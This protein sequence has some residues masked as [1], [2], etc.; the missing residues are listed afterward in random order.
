[1][2]FG[3]FRSTPFVGRRASGAD[4]RIKHRMRVDRLFLLDWRHAHVAPRRR[5]LVGGTGTA[6]PVV[7][8][9]EW[10]RCSDVD[11]D[12]SLSGP[13]VREEWGGE[14]S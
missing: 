5:K 7:A 3:I 4:D 13:Q 10:P 14:V 2:P 11:A 8:G 6:I 9:A 12:S 1:M